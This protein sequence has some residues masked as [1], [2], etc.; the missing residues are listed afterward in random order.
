MPPKY[1]LS[2]HRASALTPIGN[3]RSVDPSPPQPLTQQRDLGQPDC[4][5]RTPPK[6]FIEVFTSQVVEI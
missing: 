1:A 5:K 3:A 6:V 2:R 4:P